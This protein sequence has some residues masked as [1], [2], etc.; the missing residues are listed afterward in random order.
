MDTLILRGFSNYLPKMH[1]LYARLIDFGAVAR[2]PVKYTLYKRTWG[3]STVRIRKL[4]SSGALYFPA[5]PK[6]KLQCCLL[7]SL[8]ESC[9]FIGA[10]A[11][12]SFARA[13]KISESATGVVFSVTLLLLS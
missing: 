9:S 4:K 7:F 13:E 3:W 11:A 5:G 8:P 2:L 12:R 6:S 1:F 10:A